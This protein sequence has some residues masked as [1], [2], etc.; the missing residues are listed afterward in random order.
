MDLLDPGCCWCVCRLS[1]L[2]SQSLWEDVCFPIRQ[3]DRSDLDFWCFHCCLGGDVGLPVGQSGGVA[4]SEL[5][6][7]SEGGRLMLLLSL[8][9][10][11][12]LLLRNISFSVGKRLDCKRRAAERHAIAGSERPATRA[13]CV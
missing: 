8:D 4:S 2:W 3:V 10:F 12:V 6:L 7:R 9:S 5:D 1:G 13:K 11:L